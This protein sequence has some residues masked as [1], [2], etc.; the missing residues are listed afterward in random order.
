[1]TITC[2]VSIS[3][4]KGPEDKEI[5]IERVVTTLYLHFVNKNCLV[6][7]LQIETYKL[8]YIASPYDA[9]GCICSVND[10]L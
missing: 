2:A 5:S 1:M 10:K 8:S 6:S 9:L 7:L 3:K 4:L